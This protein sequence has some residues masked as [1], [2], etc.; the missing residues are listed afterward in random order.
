MKNKLFITLVLVFFSLCYFSQTTNHSTIESIK[1]GYK[2][3][4][5]TGGGMNLSNIQCIPQATITLKSNNNA[6]KIHFKMYKAQ[7]NEL[8]F[9]ISQD[10]NAS[11]NV[12]QDGIL[13]FKNSSGVINISN[14]AT[15]KL[16]PYKYVLQTEDAQNNKSEEFEEV[17]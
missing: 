16:E 10:L 6:A 9:E 5:G 17:H 14:G 13:L 7:N 11:T 1:V 12:N 2:S 8:V 3:V 15:V 4:P